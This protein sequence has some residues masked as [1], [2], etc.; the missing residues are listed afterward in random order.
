MDELGNIVSFLQP[1]QPAAQPLDNVMQGLDQEPAY[2]PAQSRQ[3]NQQFAQERPHRRLSA[4]DT[5]GRLAD[6]FARVGGAEALY[7]PTLDARQDRERQIDLDGL[8]RQQEQ[9]KITSGQ[10]EINAQIAARAGSVVR[11]LQA[12][13]ARGGDVNKALPILAQQAGLPA[14][15]VAL[16]GQALQSDPS[17][18]D[19]L[20]A[21]LNGVEKTQYGLNPI[22]LTDGNG[23]QKLIQPSQD[24]GFHEIPL[25]EGF[26][27][28][29][30]IQVVDNGLSQTPLDKKTGRPIAPAIQN[31]GKLSPDSVPILGADGRPVGVRVLPGSATDRNLNI[32]ENPQPK[33]AGQKQTQAIQKQREAVRNVLDNVDEMLGSIEQ[34]KTMGALSK[35]GDSAI[36]NVSRYLGTTGIGQT[37]N[38][39]LGSKA[40]EQ[41]DNISGIANGILAQMKSALALTG[42]QL[43]TEKEAQRYVSI[44]NN[45]QTSYNNM[46]AAARRLKALFASTIGEQTAPPKTKPASNKTLVY[47]PKTGKIE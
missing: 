12:I 31:T 30:G 43:N 8:R 3:F 9:Q 22:V 29:N 4:L 36:D 39:A 11:G 1:Q 5:I 16:F 41:R 18:L 26:Q 6:V 33:A 47:N 42:Q 15:Q 19:A 2:G 7:Q 13:R 46:V 17:A 34:L 25:P 37:V 28:A 44:I 45:P 14:D 27:P 23:H 24:G 10:N 35:P 40:Q 21:Q 32:R 38:R 20:A